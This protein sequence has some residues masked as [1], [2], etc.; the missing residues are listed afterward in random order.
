MSPTTAAIHEVPASTLSVGKQLQARQAALRSDAKQALIDF[1]ARLR[2]L[3]A[4][5]ADLTK[6]DGVFT[7]M[8]TEALNKFIAY[9]EGTSTML[10]PALKADATFASKPNVPPIAA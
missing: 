2:A 6:V 1:E 4:E 10:E 3:T 8:S 5:A 9:A 7:P